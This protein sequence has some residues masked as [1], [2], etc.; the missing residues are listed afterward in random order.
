[1]QKSN[2]TSLSPSLSHS[3]P[4]LTIF[5]GILH[6]PDTS[7]IFG[8]NWWTSFLFH[9]HKPL[10][11]KFHIPHLPPISLRTP[12]SLLSLIL[13][14]IYPLLLPVANPLHFCTFSHFLQLTEEHCSSNSTLSHSLSFS[15]TC[16]FLTHYYINPNR[17][18]VKSRRV[19]N[20][21]TQKTQIGN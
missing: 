15:L 1:M 13:E 20:L 12:Y 14:K 5:L 18:H 4:W 3:P 6:K 16:Q 11:E 2:H 10:K 7:P 9:W 19:T 21:E 17:K 8:L